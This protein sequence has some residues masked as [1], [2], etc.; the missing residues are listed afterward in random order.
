MDYP[1]FNL[2]LDR[3]SAQRL[4]KRSLIRSTRPKRLIRKRGRFAHEFHFMHSYS[5]LKSVFDRRAHPAKSRG[6]PFA[7]VCGKPYAI[8][9]SLLREGQSKTELMLSHW[10]QGMREAGS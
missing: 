6:P 3:A 8:N 1:F 2:K 4:R 9:S 7:E 10:V 5:S